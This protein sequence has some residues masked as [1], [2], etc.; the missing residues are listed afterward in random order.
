MKSPCRIALVLIVVIH[1]ISKPTY[2]GANLEE[3]SDETDDLDEEEDVEEERG[4]AAVRQTQD[5]LQSSLATETAGELE[6]PTTSPARWSSALSTAVS[7]STS[8]STTSTRGSTTSLWTSP[9]VP[10]TCTPVSCLNGGS[11]TEGAVGIQCFC[12]DQFTG[13]YCESLV[14]CQPGTC[15]TNVGC[16]DTPVGPYCMCQGDFKG[17]LCQQNDFPVQCSGFYCT[18][19]SRYIG[20]GGGAHRLFSRQ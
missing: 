17:V 15:G 8:G 1:I 5:G 3:D 6:T 13:V 10:T 18:D 11:C 2:V 12:P 4:W 16:V 9:T 19:F 7:D 20:T 14:A